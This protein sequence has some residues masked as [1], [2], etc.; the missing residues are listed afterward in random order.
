[1]QESCNGAYLESPDRKTVNGCPLFVHITGTRFL[2]Y[3][4]NGRWIATASIA[5]D[6]DLAR[7]ASCGDPTPA[8]AAHWQV[9]NGTG[10][11]TV[12]GATCEKMTGTYVLCA[13]PCR[14]A[15]YVVHKADV[16]TSI[17]KVQFA[18]KLL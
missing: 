12:R 3:H 4:P 11:M 14:A 15:P 6:V 10:W 5:S 18:P 7:S 16:R 8:Q 9:H 13:I 1:M 17:R 2:C